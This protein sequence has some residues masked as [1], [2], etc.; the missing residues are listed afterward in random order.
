MPSKKRHRGGQPGNQNARKHGFYSPYMSQPEILELFK[1][2]DHGGVDRR[3]AV[4]RIKLKSALLADPANHRVLGD[5]SRQ[6]AKYYCCRNYVEKEDYPEFKKFIRLG[7][8]AAAEQFS[9]TNESE[10]G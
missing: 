10:S 4:T 6:L 3:V 9:Q 8:I 5:A 1:I 2:L 7:I